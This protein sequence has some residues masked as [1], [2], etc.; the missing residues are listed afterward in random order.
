MPRPTPEK[1]V[2]RSENSNVLEQHQENQSQHNRPRHVGEESIEDD[3]V[4]GNQH[5]DQHRQYP[6]SLQK[7]AM[8]HEFNSDSEAIESTTASSCRKDKLQVADSH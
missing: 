4:T 8:R 7:K 2:N 5:G 6:R 3:H 1:R